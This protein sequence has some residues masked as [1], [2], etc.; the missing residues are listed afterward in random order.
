M[1][2]SQSI[3]PTTLLY[4][5]IWGIPFTL[6]LWFYSGPGDMVGPWIIGSSIFALIMS[7]IINPG[8]GRQ[9]V[10]SP[11]F[12]IGLLFLLFLTIQYVNSPRLLIFNPMTSRW[13]YAPAKWDQLPFSFNKPEGFEMLVWFTPVVCFMAGWL[14]NNKLHKHMH[15]IILV[16]LLNAAAMTVY[17]IYLL[18]L[19]GSQDQL[20]ITPTFF[21]TFGYQNH[22]SA[23]FVMVMGLSLFLLIR[24][25]NKKNENTLYQI[26][27]SL[28]FL[29]SVAATF[30]AVSRSGIILLTVNI[31]FLLFFLVKKKRRRLQKLHWLKQA[32]I[33]GLFLIL[34][35]SFL[36]IIFGSN[37]KGLKKE[38]SI[39]TPAKITSELTSSGRYFHLRTGWAAF[40]DHKW[41]G[42]GAWGY[43][44][45]IE[46]YIQGEEYRLVLQPGS[47]NIHNDPLQFL[48]EFGIVGFTLLAILFIC[49]CIKIY[50]RVIQ[51][52]LLSAEVILAALILT[53]V[54]LLSLIDIP[55]RHISNLQLFV[56][57]LTVIQAANMKTSKITDGAL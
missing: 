30:L 29:L 10:K 5:L 14:F 38:F 41:F 4:V 28:S 32:K 43:R 17:G 11:L 52:S 16:A 25:L 36:L 49:P 33:A 42:T 46:D 8:L 19:V 15:A 48:T 39:L 18:I 7:C 1:N 57:L 27:I 26:L 22:A 51:P 3:T 56:I 31:A 6:S 21:G 37:P 12:Y 53:E 34:S 45:I 44:H 24:T 20:N 2:K 9:L 23:F 40:Q 55:F 47:A 13:D 50:K 35:L 54:I